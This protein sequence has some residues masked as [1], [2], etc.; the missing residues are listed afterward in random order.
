VLPRRGGGG[1]GFDDEREEHGQ[2]QRPP[3]LGAEPF[4]ENGPKPAPSLVR[5]V[6]APAGQAGLEAAAVEPPQ[7]GRLGG[8]VHRP[9]GDHGVAGE[10]AVDARLVAERVC[11]PCR[12]RL[13]RAVRPHD[14]VGPFGH[15][16]RLTG[17]V[18]RPRRPRR[19]PC[20]GKPVEQGQHR[21]RHRN[22]GSVGVQGCGQE[23]VAATGASFTANGPGGAVEEPEQ[24]R[25]RA[26][27]LAREGVD[28]PEPRRG[29]PAQGG[30]AVH[31]RET[32]LS[33]ERRSEAPRYARVRQLA[34]GRRQGFG[35]QR[36]QQDQRPGCARQSGGAGHVHH[37]VRRSAGA[38]AHASRVGEHVQRVRDEGHVAG[39]GHSRRSRD[40]HNEMPGVVNME[41][42]RVDLDSPRHEARRLSWQPH[43]GGRAGGRRSC[44]HEGVA[45][46]EAD[47]HRVGASPADRGRDCAPLSRDRHEAPAHH[48]ACDRAV[49]R[50]RCPRV[51]DDHRRRGTVG[52]CRPG[53]AVRL[54]V[55]QDMDLG[56]APLRAG[57]E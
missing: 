20:A 9:G 6:E 1:N 39:H 37:D 43:H 56:R 2:E 52:R 26:G 16:G 21:S 54:Q 34:V 57:R 41:R 5:D 29:E 17:R 49:R 47:V 50:R 4:P 53:Q 12:N 31:R 15:H 23:D 13:A 55:R 45:H 33:R 3:E 32:C 10:Q 36:R 28:Q 7:V 11:G 19:R 8:G 48:H 18:L 30:V 24:H 46:H 35:L 14:G 40:Q 22:R 38:P 51:P 42:I 44:A 27:L 25:I